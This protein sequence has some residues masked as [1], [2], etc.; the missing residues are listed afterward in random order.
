[1]T[2]IEIG[3]NRITGK[4]TADQDKLLFLSVPYSSGFQA[5]VNGEPVK[6][7]KAYGMF[8][9]IEIPEGESEIVLTYST[10]GLRAGAALSAV[11]LAGW[12]AAELILA[13]RRK[14]KG[15]GG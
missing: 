5:E 1:M 4:V 8:M 14:R 11:C 3:T 13:R 10:P 9:A 12:I 7:Y 2:D 15:H 6:I